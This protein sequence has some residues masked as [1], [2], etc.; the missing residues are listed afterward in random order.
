[1]SS[2]FIDP[3]SPCALKYWHEFN[4]H[5]W[6][7]KGHPFVGLQLGNLLQQAG[8]S[9]IQLDFRPLH[10]DNQ[11]PNRRKI[12]LEYFFNIFKSADEGLVKAGR[13]APGMIDQVK[14]EFELA[15]NQPQS[16]FHYSFV[17]AE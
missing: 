8:Y 6:S 3:Y 9:D 11:S 12:F 15:M 1:N 5:Q 2:L 13:V 17:R 4:D 10:F 16:V 14:A 7:I